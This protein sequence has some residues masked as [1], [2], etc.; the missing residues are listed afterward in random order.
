MEIFKF[1]SGLLVLVHVRIRQCEFRCH[2]LHVECMTLDSFFFALSQ[3][4]AY[5][6]FCTRLALW[7]HV[8]CVN[9]IADH[10]SV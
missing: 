3:F 1:Y 7:A 4:F 2:G 9:T 6:Q 10:G 8:N 5:L